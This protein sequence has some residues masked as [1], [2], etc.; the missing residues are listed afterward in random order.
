MIACPTPEKTGRYATR[1]G[2][3]SAARRAQIGVGQLLHPYPCAC[4]W[5]HLSRTESSK[6]LPGDQP[7]P[8][9]VER[10]RTIPDIAF[11]GIV[12][13]DA[14]GKAPMPDRI[15]LRHPHNLRRW[16]RM[17][18]EL[19]TDIQKQRKDKHDDQS[20]AAHDWH[21]RADAY[22]AA[23]RVLAAECRQL[24]SDH[25]IKTLQDAEATNAAAKEARKE[26]RSTA[27]T[28]LSTP[29]TLEA[30][31]ARFTAKQETK[32]LRR[33]A[34]EAAIKRLID[35]HG[36]EWCQLLAEECNRLGAELP[37]RVTKYL[38]THNPEMEGAA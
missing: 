10:L 32:E 18:G 23:L 36:P 25:H 1:E 14:T 24:Q 26:A 21:K 4:T 17:L 5:W 27:I 31:Q 33:I 6:P 15:A 35:N 2:A 13:D 3:E 20:L 12:A 34:G 9:D 22:E 30:K 29:E 11:R 8:I 37:N 16:Q 38:H 28:T 19:I 7:D